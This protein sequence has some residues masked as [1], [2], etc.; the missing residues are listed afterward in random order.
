MERMTV[1]NSCKSKLGYVFTS[2]CLFVSKIAQKQLNSFS[3]NLVEGCGLDQDQP[4]K[5]WFRSRIFFSLSL[6]FLTIYSGNKSWISMNKILIW[7]HL[8]G[9]LVEVCALLC[10][11]LLLLCSHLETLSTASLLT[12]GTMKQTEGTTASCP[13]RFRTF[14]LKGWELLRRAHSSPLWTVIWNRTQELRYTPWRKHSQANTTSL[15][16]EWL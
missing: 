5:V 11:I 10:A 16:C 15:G 2:V 8:R 1:S 3:Q 13:E 7:F 4:N 6:T 14:H 12:G 9:Q